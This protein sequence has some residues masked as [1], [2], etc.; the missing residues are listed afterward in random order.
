[1]HGNQHLMSQQ[2]CPGAQRATEGYRGHGC[3]HIPALTFISGRGDLL[4]VSC[5]QGKSD[6]N[7]ACIFDGRENTKI[8]LVA[9]IP[10]LCLRESHPDPLV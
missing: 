3:R 2:D 9:R 1:M 4:V 8:T 7:G 6:A 10:Q 5:R